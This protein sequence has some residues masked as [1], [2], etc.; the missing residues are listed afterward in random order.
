MRIKIYCS[1]SIQKGAGDSKKLC[2]TNAERLMISDGASPVPIDF[3]NPDDPVVSLDDH[4]AL[5]GRDM[6]QIK[7]SDAVVIDA[8]ERRGIGIGVE[9][10]AAKH[11][12]KPVIAIL[13]PNSYYRQDSLDYRGST[14]AKYVHPHLASLLDAYLDDFVSAGRWLRDNLSLTSPLSHLPFTPLG[15]GGDI[16]DKAVDAYKTHLLP[17]DEPMKSILRN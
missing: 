17:Y 4:L 7:T 11:F 10:L 13:P 3:L 8:R 9:L 14:A 5:F 15:N 2:W 1:G 12:V 16:L 6:F